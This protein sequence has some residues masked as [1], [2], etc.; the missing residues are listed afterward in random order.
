MKKRPAAD[1]SRPWPK[2][3]SDPLRAAVT[4]GGGF[5]GGALID[6]LLAENI[7]VAALIRDPARVNFDKRVEIIKGD[8]DSAVALSEIADGADMFI[9]LAGVT[10]PRTRD[11]YDHVNV[12]GAARAAAAAA[13]AGAKFVHASSMSA[14]EPGVS[15]YARS[16]RDSET[17]VA[18]ASGDNPWIALRLPAIYGPGDRATLP[19]FK[20]VKSGFALA[21]A[22]SPPARA[23][24]LYVED[25]ALALL[26]AGRASAN[27]A[28][29][30]VGDEVRDGREWR[31][32]GERLGNIMNKK[33]KPIAVPRPVVAMFHNISRAASSI[34]GKTPDIREGQVN[35][36]F[37]PDWVAADNLF[38]DAVDWRPQTPL[39]EGF[40]TTVRWY[41]ENALL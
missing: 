2:P 14:R 34:L 27:G 5:V 30:E 29:F 33:V 25:A 18:D 38:S 39:S 13:K 7:E 4:G 28:V 26:A 19:F 37:H 20:L 8:L 6:T 9:H 17:A 16:K 3:G 41:R 36:F 21:P 31:E 15:P 1:C 22:T 12:E 40:A 24:I 35:E 32:I 10:F 11:L 23:S